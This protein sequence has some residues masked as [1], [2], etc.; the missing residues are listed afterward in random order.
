[1]SPV[2]KL[3]NRTDLPGSWSELRDLATIHV[4]IQSPALAARPQPV[5]AAATVTWLCNHLG[6][7][8]GCS[9]RVI[10]P[11]QYDPQVMTCGF[12]TVMGMI[13]MTTGID[14]AQVKGDPGWLLGDRYRVQISAASPATREQMT[15]FLGRLLKR[16]FALDYHIEVKPA[17]VYRLELGKGGPKFHVSA[18]Q[19]QTFA[20]LRTG[21]RVFA[22]VPQ[23]V[24]FLNSIYYG[25]FGGLDHPVE[26]GT[27][28]TGTYDIE[29]STGPGAPIGSVP[30]LALLKEQLGLIAV[31]AQG[32]E[33]YL[34]VDHVQH[35]RGKWAGSGE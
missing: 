26:D 33:K 31:R 10:P 32:E 1:M 25:K 29:I 22:S 11:V 20:A 21:T 2:R 30:W 12:C 6:P 19:S 17:P 7:G 13:T 14:P 9:T 16:V 34:V 3:H 35:F 28:L 8:G 15:Q 18:G 24:R 27:G 23:L 4:R 5:M